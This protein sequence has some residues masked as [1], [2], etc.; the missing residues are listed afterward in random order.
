MRYRHILIA[1]MLGMG[2]LWCRA[3]LPVSPGAESFY[4]RACSMYGTGNYAGA[5]DQLSRYLAVA[6]PQEAASVSDRARADMLMLRSRLMRGEFAQTRLAADG[7]CSLH[8]G[9]PLIPQ[10]HLVLAMCDFY[11]GLYSDYIH[12]YEDMSFASVDPSDRA[13]ADFCYAVSLVECGVAERARPV[14]AAM[15]GDPDFG[16]LSGF[17]LAYIDYLDGDY[18]SAQA[19]FERL[20]PETASSMGADFYLAQIAFARKEYKKVLDSEASLLRAASRLDSDR[21]P[22][23]A[24]SWRILGESA[25]YTGNR[26]KAAEN[27]ARYMR[28]PKLTTSPTAPY[29]LGVM[30]YDDGRFTEAEEYLSAVTGAE[31]A[32]GQSASLY[33]G[34]SAARRGDYTA[35][36]MSFDKAARQ[37]YDGGVAETALYNYAAS[38]AAGGR[39]PFGS[40]STLLEE[41]GTRY[42]DSKY[43]A[44]VDE[45]L[46]IGY[47]AEKRYLKALE[48]LDRIKRPSA[49]VRGLISQ[50]LYELGVSELASGNARE[51]EYYLRRAVNDGGNDDLTSQSRLWLAEALYSQKKYDE[52]ARTYSLYLRGASRTDSNRGQ[53]YY[54]MGYALYQTGD[55]KASR[56]A[57][58]DAL[59]VTGPGA[60]AGALRSD[61]RLR[62]ADCDN[63]MGNVKAA[64]AAYQEAAADTQGGGHDYAALQAACLKGV[65]GDEAGKKA[66]LEAMMARWPKSTWTQQALYELSQACL[67]TDDFKGAVSA[68]ERLARL[69]PDSQMLRESKVQT[70]VRYAETGHEKEAVDMYKAI[71]S[72]WPTSAQAGAAS[73]YLMSYYS[74]KGR[75]GEYMDYLASVPGAPRPEADK[76]DRMAYVSALSATESR[77]TDPAPMEE[78]LRNYPRGRYCPDALITLAQVY[79]DTRNSDKALTALDQILTRYSHSDSAL[80]ALRMKADISLAKGDRSAAERLY[81]E[82]L[83]QGGAEYA[84]QAYRGLMK[85][86]A[87]PEDA[88]RYA[89]TYLTLGSL[90]AEE[91]FEANSLKADALIQAGRTQEAMALL[92]TLAA[93]PYTSE[94]GAAAVKMARICL[95]SGNAREAEKLMLEFTDKGCDD[96]DQLAMG[97]I[98]L[99]EAYAAQGDNKRARQYLESLQSNYPGDNAEVKSLIANGLKKYKQ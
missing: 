97:Y 52:A 79:R 70:A 50:A 41:F 99:A 67:A 95:Q 35:A 25:Y 53:A 3:D 49:S 63:Y 84:G 8:A 6:T 68:Q 74:D 4:R 98:V 60:L 73:E 77:P 57:L 47:M 54:D 59:N 38:V 9:S 96:F 48:K 69:A 28:Q 45:Y 92:R 27:L 1:A 80:P 71:I 34:Q 22:A 85:S 2:T 61:A 82:L 31:S 93:D 26:A 94:G 14:F 20:D 30:A 56:K 87:D 13:Q 24:E 36:A 89:D 44:A 15:A 7:F 12:A 29:L 76:M 16:P 43:T 40:A 88:V 11:E 19:R 55:Y 64:L 51:A 72:A 90:T 10:A 18:R 5:I 17:Y 65:M 83:R 39:V 42:P 66:G 23:V 81:G 91:R 46:A 37:P 86:A 75:I 78:Y 62:M 32:I 21:L 58:E 33:M